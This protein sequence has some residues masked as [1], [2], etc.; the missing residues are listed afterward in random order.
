MAI[1]KKIPFSDKL[2]KHTLC[3]LMRIAIDSFGRKIINIVII[4]MKAVIESAR[5]NLSIFCN[6]KTIQ[7]SKIAR[8]E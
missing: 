2:P 1:I 7:M 6:Q 4:I 8:T 3:L 5:M